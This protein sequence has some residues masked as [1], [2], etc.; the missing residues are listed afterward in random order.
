VRRDLLEEIP[1]TS[2]GA[3]ISTE[4]VVRAVAA[5]GRVREVGVHHRP[6]VAGEQSGANPRV[7]LRAFRELA[8][9]QGEL[10][11]LPGRMAMV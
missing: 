1:L 3:M 10:R 11:G 2:G 4:L 6:R 7:V 8:R 9:L 5:G